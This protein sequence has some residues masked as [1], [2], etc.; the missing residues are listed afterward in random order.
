MLVLNFVA[1]IVPTLARGSSFSWLLCSFDINVDFVVVIISLLSDTAR[2]LRL[3]CI[4]FA[5]VQ[6][7]AT[8]PRNPGSFQWRMIL[9]TMT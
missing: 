8:S 6:E 7:P 2:A 9:E 1:Q 5:P 4:I 3:S